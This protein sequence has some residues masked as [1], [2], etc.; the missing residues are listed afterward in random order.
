LDQGADDLPFVLLTMIPNDAS[1]RGVWQ[2]FSGLEVS[3]VLMTAGRILVHLFKFK[4]PCDV[5]ATAGQLNSE[6]GQTIDDLALSRIDQTLLQLP[7]LIRHQ[8]PAS[9][10]G[11]YNG[12]RHQYRCHADH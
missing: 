12:I 4:F 7:L 3:Q 5:N 2:N 1:T 9:R 10:Y 6:D 8:F 11:K